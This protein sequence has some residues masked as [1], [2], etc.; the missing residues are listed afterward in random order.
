[1]SPPE[2]VRQILDGFA[3]DQ[4]MTDDRPVLL[5]VAE[6]RVLVYTGDESANGLCG[7]ADVHKS[8]GVTLHRAPSQ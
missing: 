4:Q 7:L 5:L 2:L 6:E 3:N 1:V 8:A